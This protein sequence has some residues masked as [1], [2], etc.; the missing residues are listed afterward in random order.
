MHKQPRRYVS[1]TVMHEKAPQGV[2][3]LNS[4]DWSG[5]IYSGWSL[6]QILGRFMKLY[7]EARTIAIVTP[8]QRVLWVWAGPKPVYP[9]LV[10]IENWGSEN[11]TVVQP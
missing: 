9:S 4:N 6:N 2:F 3:P 5:S 10:R 1:V 8:D 7:P 11:E